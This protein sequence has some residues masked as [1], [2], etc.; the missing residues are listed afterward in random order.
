[1]AKEIDV[2]KRI[3]QLNRIFHYLKSKGYVHTKG[4]LAEQIGM[5]L[6]NLSQAFNGNKSYL[7][8]NLFVYK[9]GDTYPNVFNIE[10]LLTG[11]GEMLKNAPRVESQQVNGDGNITASGRSNINITNENSKLIEELQIENF[12]LKAELKAKESEI[13]WLRTMVE[14]LSSTNK[15]E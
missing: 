4:Q 15:Y 9:I 3:E 10:W 1:M 6:P 14:K 11:D 5:A 7:T 2:E 12:K 8:D 13:S